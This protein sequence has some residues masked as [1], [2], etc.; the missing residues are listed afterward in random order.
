[1]IYS[2]HGKL[3]HIEANL[4]VIECG[5]VGYGVRTSAVTIS[6]LPAM[7]ETATLY[8]YLHVTESGLDLTPF[9]DWDSGSAADS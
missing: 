8:T 9:S 4:A 3:I 1:M 5:G 7:G 2:V 6:K